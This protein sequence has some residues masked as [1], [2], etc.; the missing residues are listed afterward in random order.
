MR[1][2]LVCLDGRVESCNVDAMDLL[3]KELTSS[4]D[5]H[6]LVGMFENR[7]QR[8]LAE[9]LRQIICL[10]DFL[11]AWSSSQI[12]YN[13]RSVVLICDFVASNHFQDLEF[14]SKDE[15]FFKT[16]WEHNVPTK[17]T[18]IVLLLLLI[19]LPPSIF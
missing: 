16:T 7:I 14:M 10:R 5:E 1:Q 12:S 6:F 4:L 13:R 18:D 9:S 11:V 8:G 19:F 3:L 17:E 2:S 15:M